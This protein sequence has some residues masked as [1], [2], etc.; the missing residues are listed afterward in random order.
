MWTKNAEPIPTD[1][2]APWIAAERST[3]WFV[4]SLKFVV[5]VLFALV[6]V[7]VSPTPNFWVIELLFTFT[8]SFLLAAN[9]N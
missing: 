4:V 7:I 3:V 9:A 8:L 5:V 6:E 1:P 2:L